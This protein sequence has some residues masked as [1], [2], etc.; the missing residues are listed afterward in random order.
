MADEDEQASGDAW[1]DDISEER[2]AY[3]EQRLQAWEQEANHGKR[4]GPF[5]DGP[6][7]IGVPL[8]G[9]DVFWL[10][11]RTAMASG[12]ETAIT[13]AKA[14]L[15]DKRFRPAV[16]ELHLEGAVLHGAHLEGAALSEARLE[17]ANLTEATLDKTSSLLGA[18]LTDVSLDQLAYD[19]V[20]LT[21]VD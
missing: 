7:E 11:A 21:V 17:G 15:N 18:V 5:D 16:T 13:H 14:I 8:T 3:L 6:D 12:D 10:A 19:N 4:K 9:A 20:N 1:G 2:K